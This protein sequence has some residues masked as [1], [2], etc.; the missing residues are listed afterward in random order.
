MI[1]NYICVTM[2]FNFLV[3]CNTILWVYINNKL[4]STPVQHLNSKLIWTLSLEMYVTIFVT[5]WNHATIFFIFSAQG[6]VWRRGW[7]VFLNPRQ[8]QV[9]KLGHSSYWTL[10]SILCRTESSTSGH[11]SYW[12]L[13]FLS[14][15]GM[16]L[17]NG[18]G[19]E[20]WETWLIALV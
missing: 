7:A 14:Y 8:K 18:G 16:W 9:L 4:K 10:F 13:S 11:S 3:F 1:Q 17:S 15:L 20:T 5:H 12:T 6:Q 19:M 2:G